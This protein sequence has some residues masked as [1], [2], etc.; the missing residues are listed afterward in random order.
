MS[1]E[2][3]LKLDNENAD[4]NICDI[5][6]A[7]DSSTFIRRIPPFLNHRTSHANIKLIK[8]V[9]LIGREKIMPYGLIA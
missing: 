4:L 7:L 5:F 1:D 8:A 9:I 3:G 2:C 6:R